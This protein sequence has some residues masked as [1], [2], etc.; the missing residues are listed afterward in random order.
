MNTPDPETLEAAARRL[1][2]VCPVM[3]RAHDHLGGTPWRTRPGGFSGL[4][5]IIAYQQLSTKAAATIWGRVEQRL[6][7]V[8][9]EAVLA[10]AEADMRAAGLSRPKIA[11]LRSIATAVQEGRL[12]MDRV[13]A[14]PDDEARAEMVAVK[15]IGPWTADVY[16]MFC[17]GRLD[18][19]PFG[20]LGLI[21]AHRLLTDA[22]ERMPAK[23][24]QAEA[25][26]WRPHRAVAAA[27]LWGYINAA[28]TLERGGA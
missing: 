26:K 6:G 18:V 21:E 14:A 23:A 10:A 11:H 4:A 24:F 2:E 15:G 25:E 20:D 16:L 5:R 12:D 17:L 3:R 8:T 13:A 19:F 1:R 9:P 28:R 7:E 22:G 27:L